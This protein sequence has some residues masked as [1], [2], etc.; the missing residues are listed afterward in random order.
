MIQTGRLS[1]PQENAADVS[2]EAQG[3]W[4]QIQP[5]VRSLRPKRVLWC[6]QGSS[7]TPG[8]LE[9]A[10]VLASVETGICRAEALA[11]EQA[12]LVICTGVLEQTA[13]AELDALLSQL[14]DVS[15][16]V[17]FQIATTPAG[18]SA[19]GGM[20]PCTV[21][22][23]DWW[24]PKLRQYFEHVE[25]VSVS[26]HD[27]VFK[28]W[29]TERR[30][31]FRWWRPERTLARAAREAATGDSVEPRSPPAKPDTVRCLACGAAAPI[32]LGAK[33]GCHVW[34][35]PHCRLVFV[36]PMPM[37]A[38]IDAFYSHHPRNDK[39]LRKADGKYRR[40]RWRIMRLLPRV[41]GRRFLD[42]GCSI[43]AS[44]E[45]ARRSGFDATG[46]DLDAQSIRIATERYPHCRFLH[47]SS[48][49]LAHTAE[50]FDLL[51]CTEVIE[52]VSD[53]ESF[54]DDLRMLLNPGGIVLLTTPHATHV[55]VPRN[56]LNWQDLKP[57]EHVVLFGR[58]SIK[59]LFERRGLEVVSAPLR[60]KTSLK[61]IAR[62]AA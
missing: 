29:P 50:R 27:V 59:A 43:G 4:R 10:Q 15:R 20:A 1:V 54:V 2:T 25:P 48:S 55:R 11:G 31:V 36:N 22:Y 37:A 40:A 17:V 24:R 56:I 12:D 35:C 33:N 44:V 41:P 61:V 14:R 46:I 51:F 28:T 9:S 62:R 49:A 19:A 58:P 13:L 39:Y 38:E 8:P 21:R 30:A 57:P 23:A 26:D 52:H 47:T 53:P 32:W 42:V 16:H 6:V 5:D 45:A 3:L 7:T 60:W 18:G 34:R